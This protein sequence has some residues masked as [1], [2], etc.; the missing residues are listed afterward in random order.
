MSSQYSYSTLR[1]WRAAQRSLRQQRSSAASTTS[2]SSSSSSTGIAG[3]AYYRSLHCPS[4]ASSSSA[5]LGLS[6]TSTATSNNSS[7]TANPTIARSLSTGNPNAWWPLREPEEGTGFDNFLQRRGKKGDKKEHATGGSSGDGGGGDNN[8]NNNDKKKDR[9]YNNNKGGGGDE[10]SGLVILATM[11][12]ATAYI[13]SKSDSSESSTSSSSG[14]GDGTSSNTGGG[15]G[16]GLFDS[17][18]ANAN[19]NTHATNHNLD[20]T[21]SEF[22]QLLEHDSI[23]KIVIHQGASSRGSDDAVSTRARVYLKPGANL[24]FGSHTNSSSSSHGMMDPHDHHHHSSSSSNHHN[25]NHNHEEDKTEWSTSSTSTDP[26]TASISATTTASATPLVYRNLRIG[27]AASLERKLEEAQ[28]A[29]HRPP[30][31]DIPVQYQVDS[32][33][34]HE[35]LS[36][37]PW[38]LL[39]AF[40]IATFRGAAGRI[41]GVGATGSS[42][43]GGGPG[44]MFGMGKSTAQKF[45]KEMNINIGFADVAG[46][47]EAKREIMEF[48]EFLQTPDRFTQLGAKIPKGALLAV[49]YLVALLYCAVLVVL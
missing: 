19:S 20:L 31:Q 17:S 38:V 33:V 14:G 42:G 5:L 8:K 39:S 6:T 7:I 1:L 24:N 16:G 15:T 10:N 29:L 25:H 12:M 36:I 28:R 13:L 9:Q 21:W 41:G 4:A 40:L 2:T 43:G 3:S 34:T 32:G 30:S 35:L 47:N 11:I 37:L 26:S 18:S 46:C 23:F 44:G 27:S 22:L 45:T 49:R 48:V